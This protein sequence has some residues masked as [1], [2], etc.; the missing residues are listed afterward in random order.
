M[1]FI[2]MSEAGIKEINDR[3]FGI[4]HYCYYKFYIEFI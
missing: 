4:D 1:Y 2:W 3:Y